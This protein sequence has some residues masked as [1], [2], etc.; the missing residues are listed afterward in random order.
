MPTETLIFTEAPVMVSSNTIGGDDP[1]ATVGILVT[2]APATA[3]P[4]SNSVNVTGS[5]DDRTVT[6]ATPVDSSSSS[7]SNS[8]LCSAHPACAGLLQPG[9]DCCP[10][11][12]GFDF[13]CCGMDSTDTAPKEVL[14]SCT[15]NPR[16]TAMGLTEGPCC[17]TDNLDYLDC[18]SVLPDDCGDTSSSCVILA[19]DQFMREI[20]SRNQVI[21]TNGSSTSVPVAVD[22]SA[23]TGA[24]RESMVFT[25]PPVATVPVNATGTTAPAPVPAEDPVAVDPSA[26]TGS[27]TTPR[28]NSTGTTAPAPEPA[29]DPGAETEASSSVPRESMV[30]TAP[31]VA[32]APNSTGTTT[33]APAAVPE[34]DL[35]RLGGPLPSA[36]PVIAST[37]Q[38]AT[39]SAHPACAGLLSPDSD[40]CPTVLG[41]HF[42]CCAETAATEQAILPSCTENPRCT[43]MGLTDGPCCPTSDGTYLDCC[44]VLPDECAI[45]DSSCVFLPTDEFIRAISGQ[46]VDG[47]QTSE[48][49]AQ[50]TAP[51][52]APAPT[53]PALCSA[54]P[55]CEGVM[56]PDSGCCPTV[57]GFHFACCSNIEVKEPLPLCTENPECSAAGLSDGPC[58]PTTNGDYLDCCSVVP[59]ECSAGSN[60]ASCN[61]MPTDQFLR[62]LLDNAES[63]TTGAQEP[64]SGS[65]RHLGSWVFVM[66]LA[67]FGCMLR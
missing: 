20:T 30:F 1:T 2:N 38:V 11:V 29:E 27:L 13:A 36:M 17:P 7:T 6:T 9:S 57:L 22:P 4:A 55:D 16:C 8:A 37:G 41:F 3:T 24:P 54:H 18:C 33:P 53:D 48:V 58:C 49:D 19:T 42:E 43:E 47:E 35:S 40:C 67:V 45:S 46:G 59:N 61:I 15:E 31:P 14:P 56:L 66:T 28:V 5:V 25:A 12:L 44:S 26:G 23:S 65:H 32:T 50:T 62:E 52:V 51:S 10:T 63:A 21:A 34:E 39:C 60:S 64:T